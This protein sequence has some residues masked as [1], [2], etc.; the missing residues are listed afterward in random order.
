MM[1]AICYWRQS[2]SEFS[3]SF[4]KYP[5]LSTEKW[6]V[7]LWTQP[8]NICEV[9]LCWHAAP[10]CRSLSAHA[11]TELDA[12]RER[13][14]WRT[15]CVCVCLCAMRSVAC[16]T[17]ERAHTLAERELHGTYVRFIF[18]NLCYFIFAERQFEKCIFDSR[19]VS[20]NARKDDQIEHKNA[21]RLRSFTFVCGALVDAMKSYCI[22]LC[23][24]RRPLSNAK[25]QTTSS[26]I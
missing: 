13:M 14:R 26:S 20:E 3:F 18:V 10:P 25:C 8:K 17:V 21:P 1:S 6:V 11:A 12:H 2:K 22:F 4:W 23:I 5:R 19:C 7:S 9:L 24:E 15:V 16:V